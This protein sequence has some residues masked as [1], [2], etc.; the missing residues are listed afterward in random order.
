MLFE[1]IRARFA[2]PKAAL[3]AAQVVLSLVERAVVVSTRVTLAQAA[4][5]ALPCSTTETL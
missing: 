1:T 3:D 5:S 4:L 2:V